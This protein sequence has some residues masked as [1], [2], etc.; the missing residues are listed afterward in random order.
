MA[1]TVMDYRYRSAYS[2]NYDWFADNDKIMI[3]YQKCL[4]LNL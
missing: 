4:S 1:R 2:L 3:L